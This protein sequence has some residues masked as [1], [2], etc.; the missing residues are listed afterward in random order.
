MN[1]PSVVSFGKNCVYTVLHVFKSCFPTSLPIWKPK[2]YPHSHNAIRRDLY[3]DFG[4]PLPARRAVVQ[5][6]FNTPL[7]NL[8][9]TMGVSL[10]ICA[11]TESSLYISPC[12]WYR[13]YLFTPTSLR[14]SLQ[15]PWFITHA[16][17]P[18]LLR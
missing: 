16:P 15:R 5:H 12:P 9:S 10:V 4:M 13:P 8:P 1:V 7:V 18:W 14:D 2:E 6:F 17:P 3:S 11:W